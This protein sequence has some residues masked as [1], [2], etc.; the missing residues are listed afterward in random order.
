MPKFETPVMKDEIVNGY[1]LKMYESDPYY[2]VEVS[3]DGKHITNHLL[4]DRKY[5]YEQLKKRYDR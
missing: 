1:R 5:Q 3:K 2:Y 4:S